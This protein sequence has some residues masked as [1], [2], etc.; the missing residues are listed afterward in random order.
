MRKKMR[1]RRT[2][3][4]IKQQMLDASDC[5]KCFTCI[6]SLS[7]VILRVDAIQDFFILLMRIL[8]PKKDNTFT[9]S[10]HD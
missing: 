7:L 9:K 2:K 3:R 1:E 8:R 6:I 4:S 10:I 5:V